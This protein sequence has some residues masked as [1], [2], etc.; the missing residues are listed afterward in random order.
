VH[1]AE[2]VDFVRHY[3]GNSYWP[4]HAE[5]ETT[6]HG[7]AWYRVIWK[8]ILW[9]GMLMPLWCTIATIGSGKLQCH[10]EEMALKSP[11]PIRIGKVKQTRILQMAAKRLESGADIE[12]APLMI[13]SESVH[14][15]GDRTVLPPASYQK[16]L[17]PV[18]VPEPKLM[19]QSSAV[20][21]EASEEDPQADPPKVSDFI[22]AV[23]YMIFG[24]IALA[25]GLVSIAM[26]GK[27]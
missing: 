8:S 3:F 12:T 2:F 11:H 5:E 16:T 24:V 18:D 21:D 1:G 10:Q 25:A 17:Q 6:H 26:K 20:G 22:I 23:G 9:Y 19:P 7:D 4:K 15:I 14:I 13:R 27:D